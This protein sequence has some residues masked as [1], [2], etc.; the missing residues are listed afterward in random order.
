MSS[1]LSPSDVASVIAGKLS[2]S[3]AERVC[4]EVLKEPKNP[5]RCP[6][7]PNIKTQADVERIGI[8][9]WSEWCLTW[10]DNDLAAQPG[11]HCDNS[12]ITVWGVTSTQPYAVI[13]DSLE[14]GLRMIR[15]FPECSL[16]IDI[17]RAR[18]IAARF[19]EEGARL[20]PR[21][22]KAAYRLPDADVDVAIAAVAWLRD[23]PDL[24][25]WTIRQLPVPGMHTK[26]IADHAALIHSLVGREVAK[27]A[28]PRLS[29]VHLTYVDP[30][31]R[32]GGGRHHDAWTAGD[33]HQLAYRPRFVLVV[34][35]RDSRLWFPELAH[36]IVVEGAGKAA[37][38][39]LANI[40][41][42]MDS[43]HLVYW[44]DIDCEGFSI[45][46]NFR[47]TMEP[48]G[49][50]VDSIL[51]DATAHARYS[52]LGV[53]RDQHGTLLK[54]TNVRLPHLRGAECEGYARVATLGNAGFRRIEQER[55][56]LEDAVRAM[57]HVLGR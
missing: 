40:E 45:L 18:L 57:T 36:T 24:S 22:V 37:A 43:E 34:E 51:M 46:N 14:S 33:C 7:R 21:A 8:G 32:A 10:K 2:K 55:I 41:W 56:P 52:H 26:W 15:Q 13:A 5:V 17:G 53:D 1:L 44:G 29:V 30:D 54:P 35:N 4:A 49:K 9:R 6:V 28:R 31:Y 19:Q 48:L 11:V 3:W 39:S 25:T 42:I 23:H 27:E 20:T 50:H 38:A 12:E 16:G 47:A